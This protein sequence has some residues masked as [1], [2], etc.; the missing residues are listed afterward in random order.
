MTKEIVNLCVTIIAAI[1]SVVV[2]VVIIVSIT[3]FDNIVAPGCP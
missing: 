1:T 2:V 3:A